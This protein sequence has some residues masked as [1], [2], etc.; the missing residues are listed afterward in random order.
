MRVIIFTGGDP[1]GMTEIP[2]LG[3]A[4][5]DGEKRS[6]SDKQY[7]EPGMP[8]EIPVKI[9]KKII[10]TMHTDKLCG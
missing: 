5:I 2:D 1:D 6:C 4:E 3:K 9:Y 8:S 7:H 10:Y